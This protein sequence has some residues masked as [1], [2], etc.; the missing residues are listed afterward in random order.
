MPEDKEHQLIITR[1]PTGHYTID[2]YVP[3]GRGEKSDL[4]KTMGVAKGSPVAQC[5]RLLER[6]IE[7][8]HHISTY[9]DK[10]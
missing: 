1:K 6:L 2:V 4:V 5:I 9:R 8:A 10:D 7:L 3:T